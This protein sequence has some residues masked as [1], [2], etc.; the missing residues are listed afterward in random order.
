MP[1]LN[2]KNIKEQ[3]YYD[4]ATSVKEVKNTLYSKL[5]FTS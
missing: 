5:A 1:K 3:N 4:F 2:K